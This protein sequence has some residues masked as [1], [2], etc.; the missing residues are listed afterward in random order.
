MP[1]SSS[2]ANAAPPAGS[3]ASSVSFGAPSKVLAS[4]FK[5]SDTRHLSE[6]LLATRQVNKIRDVPALDDSDDEDLPNVNDLLV[7]EERKQ[8]AKQLTD[9]KRQALARQ[10]VQSLMHDDDDDELIVESDMHAVVDEEA[11]ERRVRHAKHFRPS[12]GR[13]R[14]LMLGGIGSSKA[15]KGHKAAL[16]RGKKNAVELLRESAR[17]AFRSG[18]K[19]G[20]DEAAGLTPV[21]LNRLMIESAERERAEINRQKEEEWIRRGGKAIRDVEFPAATTES[22][23]AMLE[24]GREA[25]ERR[26]HMEVDEGEASDGSDEDWVP[27]L[28]GSLSPEPNEEESGDDDG[29]ASEVEV[30]MGILTDQDDDEE[31]VDKEN[32]RP[33]RPRR[34]AHHRAVLDSDEED[35]D[36]NVRPLQNEPSFGQVLVPDTSFAG[37]NNLPL[38]RMPGMIHRGSLSSFDEP[39]EDENDKENNTQLMFDKSE[40][41]ENKAVVRHSPLP[42]RPALGPCESPLLGLEERTR[43]TLST[44]PPA[45]EFFDQDHRQADDELDRLR[46]PLKVLRDEDRDPFTF[47]PSAPSFT[48]RLQRP[49]PS[50][51][52]SPPLAFDQQAPLDFEDDEHAAAIAKSGLQPGFSDIF[53]SGSSPSVVPF[54]ASHSVGFSQWSEDEVRVH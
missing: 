21:A 34:P 53:K 47:S 45:A 15:E 51:L 41:K 10:D 54:N 36:E 38:T 43:R 37:E 35:D 9:I 4:P 48:T 12:E 32:S 31:P 17:P 44:S 26:A 50:G 14:Q 23:A 20:K 13:K 11:G 40:D 7:A 22:L 39:T 29:V 42:T 52:T 46:R 30:A 49:R 5:P 16:G 8:K 33:R 25:A 27:E 24:K 28:R 1:F 2:P 6:P 18:A 3:G 19:H